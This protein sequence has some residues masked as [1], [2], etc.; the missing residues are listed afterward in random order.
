MA[1]LPCLAQAPA[2][3]SVIALVKRLPVPVRPGRRSVDT[4]AGSLLGR[5]PAHG[6]TVFATSFGWRMAGTAGG[7]GGGVE[8]TGTAATAPQRLARPAR[9]W[10]SFT[11]EQ[12][13]S[14]RATSAAP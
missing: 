2:C 3:K 8:Q 1:P 5:I 13:G 11:A 12:F 4:G 10:W 7:G 14:K 9:C 6:P